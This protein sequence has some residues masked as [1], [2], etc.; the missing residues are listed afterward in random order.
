MTL[1]HNSVRAS[2]GPEQLCT[3]PAQGTKLDQKLSLSLYPQN[4]G[5]SQVSVLMN[6]RFPINIFKIPSYL[7]PPLFATAP[8]PKYCW[9][10]TQQWTVPKQKGPSLSLDC[11]AVKIRKKCSLSRKKFMPHAPLPLWD[12]GQVYQREEGRYTP[13]S[14]TLV[15][16]GKAKAIGSM[17]WLEIPLQGKNTT[18]QLLASKS[19][20]AASWAQR[21]WT[22]F[23]QFVPSVQ[24]V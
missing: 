10:F 22:R 20:S 6:H 18:L 3:A 11:S 24:L 15:L 14:L 5:H 1:S 2:P 9:S 16:L 12:A 8:P 21:E 4:R 19:N 23:C 7:L 17:I 13:L